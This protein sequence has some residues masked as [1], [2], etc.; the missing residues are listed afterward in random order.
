MKYVGVLVLLAAAMLAGCNDAPSGDGRH[1]SILGGFGKPRTPPG[2]VTDA[3]GKPVPEPKTPLGVKPRMV[4]AADDAVLAL[5]V[6]DD[7]VV[8]ARYADGAWSPPQPLEEIFGEAGD[9]QLATNGRGSAVAVWR[10]TVGN[11]QSLRFSRYE[12]GHWSTPDVLP[13]AL[14]RPPGDK[15]GSLTLEMDDDGNVVAEWPSGFNAQEVQT[16]RF[17]PGQGW[18]PATSEP[19]AAAPAAAP[20]NVQ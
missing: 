14:P 9:A 18:S 5:W 12:S 20:S 4:R 7:H 10:H 6:Q 3:A 15:A 11:I 2:V 16:A 1:T 13:G 17:V 8:A 19:V